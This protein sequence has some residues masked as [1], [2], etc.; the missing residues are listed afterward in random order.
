MSDPG[1][2]ISVHFKSVVLCRVLSHP[3]YASGAIALCVYLDLN[4]FNSVHSSIY[5]S[6]PLNI[7]ILLY[8]FIFMH[9]YIFI[10][11]NKISIL[12]ASLHNCMYLFKP[13]ALEHCFDNIIAK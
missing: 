7:H 3:Y 6:F 12:R 11:I 8:L 13:V 5:S 4:V 9:K 1:F 2:C 10:Y